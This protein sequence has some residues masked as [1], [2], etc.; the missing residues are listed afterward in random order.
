MASTNILVVHGPE[1]ARVVEGDRHTRRQV[2]HDVVMAIGV[3]VA[4]L[5]ADAAVETPCHPFAP[6]A[7]VGVPPNRNTRTCLP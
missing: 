2:E 6:G 3:T 7:A 1:S 4:S 5:T